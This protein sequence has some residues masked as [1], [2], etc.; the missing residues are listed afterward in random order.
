MKYNIFAAFILSCSL[1]FCGPVQ[2]LVKSS[3]AALGVANTVSFVLGAGGEITEIVIHDCPTNAAA[4][5]TA[6]ATYASGNRSVSLASI[7]LATNVVTAYATVT[8][9]VL[10]QGSAITVSGNQ[11]NRPFNATFVIK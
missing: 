2:L 10:P 1:A 6:V 3:P 11:T 4:T 7:A 5:V 8:N 9:G